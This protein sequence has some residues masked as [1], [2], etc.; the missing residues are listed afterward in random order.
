MTG[1][2]LSFGDWVERTNSR[3]SKV[4]LHGKGR[5]KFSSPHLVNFL[6]TKILPKWGGIIHIISL[7]YFSYILMLSKWKK[8]E[9]SASKVI[10]M[11]G[12]RLKN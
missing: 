8:L 11:A 6:G 12:P 3:Q 9:E 2:I 4:V 1:A 5:R 10:S 7:Y